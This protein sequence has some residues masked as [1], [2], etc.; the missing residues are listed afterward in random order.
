[1]GFGAG[2][3]RLGG[4]TTPNGQ[5]WL[6]VAANDSDQRVKD[7]ADFECDGVADEVQINLALTALKDT[8]GCVLLSEGDF[9][10]AAAITFD[11]PYVTLKGCANASKLFF[12]GTT[13]SPLLT[14]ADTTVR[15]FIRIEDMYIESTNAGDGVAID[16]NNFSFGTVRNVEIFNVNKCVE[17]IGDTNDSHYNMI[18]DC[19]FDLGAGT[20]PIAIHFDTA[21]LNYV[22][23]CRVKG[24]IATGKGLVIDES[25]SCVIINLD[26]E[27]GFDI[28]IDIISN[29]DNT[30]LVG[31]YCELNLTNLNIAAGVE[32][33]V[34]LGGFYVDATDGD[35]FNIVDG[36]TRTQILGARV[37]DSGRKTEVV[38]SGRRI[39]S[40]VSIMT[41]QATL[42]VVAQAVTATGNNFLIDTSGGAQ[43]LDTVN[44][45]TEGMIIIIGTNSSSNSGTLTEGGSPAFVLAGSADFVMSGSNHRWIGIK[46]GSN[47]I[48]LARMTP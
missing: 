38:I 48:E 12:P 20:T 32:G 31:C 13:V 26:V 28:A 11:T 19:R 25:H 36:G 22:T 14:M 29:S 40:D 9:T 33:T 41:R 10:C 34:I 6:L 17:L 47:L 35:A 23:N 30:T 8:G 24:G 44:G 45:L 37:E 42:T 21:N 3:F 16:I 1:M 7:I 43:I 46:T 27:T 18:E 4:G 15:Q 39:T 5:P 2:S